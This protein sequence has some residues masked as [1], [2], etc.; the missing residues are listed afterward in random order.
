MKVITML[1]KIFS[2]A[3]YYAQKKTWGRE[4]REEN[5]RQAFAADSV[6]VCADLAVILSA[7]GLEIFEAIPSW[8]TL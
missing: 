3:V 8:L 5:T 4:D 7:D 1:L 6:R 2:H